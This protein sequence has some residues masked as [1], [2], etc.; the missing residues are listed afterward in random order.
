MKYQRPSFGNARVYKL[1]T[2]YV[3]GLGASTVPLIT[4]TSTGIDFGNLVAGLTKVITVQCT[5]GLAA[6]TLAGC[7]INLAIFQCSN[8]L[9]TLAAGASFTMSVTLNL[10]SVAIEL[11]KTANSIAALPSSVAGALELLQTNTEVLLATLAMTGTLF[12]PNPIT[13]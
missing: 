9:V 13:L 7:S 2:S 12:N 5:A 4:C 8:A 3:Y 10:T 6:V 11:V 1:E